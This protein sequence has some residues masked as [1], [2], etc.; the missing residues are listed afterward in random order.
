MT[1]SETVLILAS[2]KVS[3]QINDLPGAPGSQSVM[4]GQGV[5]EMKEGD[6]I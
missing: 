2:L 3:R 6:E 5:A 4:W 1:G